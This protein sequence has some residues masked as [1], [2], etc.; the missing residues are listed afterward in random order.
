MT[1]ITYRSRL[2]D[3]EPDVTIL[4]ENSGLQ[5]ITKFFHDWFK[6]SHEARINSRGPHRL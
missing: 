3:Q 2:T 4:P 6:F 1:T 5:R